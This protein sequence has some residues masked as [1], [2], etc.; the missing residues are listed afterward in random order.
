MWYVPS[1]DVQ[2]TIVGTAAQAI[3]RTIEPSP[4]QDLLT[5]PLPVAIP[6]A[7]RTVNYDGF[8]AKVPADWPVYQIVTTHTGNSFSV[9]PTPGVC[10]PPVFR[11]PSVY[12]GA[13]P[14]ISCP[15][16]L[17]KTASPTDDGLWLQPSQSTT[18]LSESSIGNPQRL[19]TNGA[20]QILLT[21]GSGDDISVE[22]DVAGHRINADIGLGVNPAI[23][24]AILSSITP[25][26]AG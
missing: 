4:L 16:I 18:P 5:D 11:T 17:Q 26:S 6:S 21:P 24:E 19:I 3:A 12:F 14:G 20:S 22:I 13:N 7:W 1:L 15:P 2:I 10:G 23:A 8:Q 9:S 25:V